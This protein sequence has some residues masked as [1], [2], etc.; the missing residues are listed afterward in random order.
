MEERKVVLM[1]QFEVY[2]DE[3][4]DFE[5]KT[6]MEIM[7]DLKQQLEKT[8]MEMPGNDGVWWHFMDKEGWTFIDDEEESE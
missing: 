7:V 1:V 3:N 4:E 8:L 2:P 6:D 5:S